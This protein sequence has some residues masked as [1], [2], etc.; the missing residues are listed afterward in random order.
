MA[1]GSDV[2]AWRFGDQGS[3]SS[4]TT[5][6]ADTITD[7]D[8][9]PVAQGGDVLDLRDLLQGEARGAGASPNINDDTVGNLL[10]YLDIRTTTANG[11]T[12][13][14]IR[15]DPVNNNTESQY[16]TL[17]GV[18]LS[19]QLVPGSTLT[20]TQ[21]VENMLRSGKLITD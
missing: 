3:G 4:S 19:T 14:E 20:E 15:I 6:A 12:S 21:I 9:R 18:N 7:F 8:V 16:I 1:T 5:R 2:F 11:V 13:T 10:N 17:S